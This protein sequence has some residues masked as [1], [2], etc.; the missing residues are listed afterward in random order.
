MVGEKITSFTKLEAWKEGHV[1]VL[2][3]YKKTKEFPKDEVFGITSQIRR[4]A[5]S[6]TS[7]IAE[8]FSRHSWKEKLQFYA[9]A[10]GSLTEVENQILI[11]RDVGYMTNEEFHNLANQVVRVGKLLT[12]L[13][14]KSKTMV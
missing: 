12:G 1:F 14:K 11:A 7:N 2:A 5:V 9:I 4:A 13:L 8:G 3:I 10:M 6:I